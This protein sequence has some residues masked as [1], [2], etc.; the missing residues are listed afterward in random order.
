[1]SKPKMLYISAEDP[2]DRKS[3]S[4]I[5]FAQITQLKKYFDVTHT[6]PIR[7][8]MLCLLIKAINKILFMVI[9]KRY[10]YD[11]SLIVGRQNAKKIKNFLLQGHDVIFCSSSKDIAG[12]S[13]SIPIVYATDGTFDLVHNYYPGFSSLLRYSVK[14]SNAVEQKAIHSSSLVLFSSEWGASSAIDTYQSAKNKVH[15]IPYGANIEGP[16]SYERKERE[17]LSPFHILFIGV[18]WERK[19]GETVYKTCRLLKAKGHN[20][21]LTF[22]G[23]KPPFEVTEDWIHYIESLNKNIPEE[24]EAFKSYLNRSHLLFL[25]TKADCTPIV[26]CEAAAYGL[27]IVSTQTGGVSSLVKD[28]FNGYCLPLNATEHDFSG[29]IEKL[30][31]NNQ[32]YAQLSKNSRQLYEESF[33]WEKWGETVNE[34]IHQLLAKQKI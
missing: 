27:P 8:A 19:G 21:K 26:F 15:V 12:L 28:N 1:M 4:G 24:K 6:G 17:P 32:L 3:W 10:N 9:K 18:D 20:I 7:P 16:D 14:E 2:W 29:C 13:T 34:R 30:I 22:I 11:H 31:V 25:P 23:C 5:H 33:N